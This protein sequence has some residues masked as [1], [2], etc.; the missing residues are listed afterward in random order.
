MLIYWTKGKRE[1]V[2]QQR[3]V[4]YSSFA[5]LG[6]LPLLQSD[7]ALR[8]QPTFAT[9]WHAS[10]LLALKMFRCLRG[11]RNVTT[12]MQTS[13]S[14]RKSKLTNARGTTTKSTR[15]HGMQCPVINSIRHGSEI[16]ECLATSNMVHDLIHSHKRLCTSQ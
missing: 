12:L 16:L 11:N 15:S 10:T 8:V 13:V 4:S 1:L 14:Y 3:Y 7:F 5:L 6:A 9:L 2:E